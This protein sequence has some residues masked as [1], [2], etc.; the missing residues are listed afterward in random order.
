MFGPL[1]RFLVWVAAAH[2]VIGVIGLVALV[3]FDAPPKPMKFGFSIAIFLGTM[4]IV[5]PLLSISPGLRRGIEWTLAIT[6]I[7]EIVPIVVQALRGTTSHFNTQGP[8]NAAVWKLMAVAIV[9]ATAAMVAV[10]IIATVRP[11]VTSNGAPLDSFAATAWRAGL[12]LFFMAA[13]S[14]FNMAARM[15]HSVGGEDGGPGLPVTEWSQTH[16]DL[17]V[18]HFVALH[19]LQIIPLVAAGLGALPIA[20]AVRWTVLVATIGAY[21]VV[22]TATWLQALAARPLW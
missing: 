15:R 22:T 17:R 2:V 21:A 18:S 3:V 7:L 11:L 12:W 9:I 19:A 10:A 5:T 8:F 16:G 4:A 13:V 1:D 14:G 20:H 6:M